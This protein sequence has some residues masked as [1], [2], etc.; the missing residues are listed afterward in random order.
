M[1]NRRTVQRL[2]MFLSFVAIISVVAI[3][4]PDVIFKDE[5]PATHNRVDV[6]KLQPGS[7]VEVKRD[8][9]HVFV[10]RDFAGAIHIF[11]IPFW[12]GAYWL[13]EFDWTHP[14]VPCA[15]FGPDNNDGTLVIDGRFRCREPDHGEFFRREH[16]WTYAG[17]NK[18]YRTVDLKTAKH[19]IDENVVV[20]PRA[21]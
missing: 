6:S 12:D 21:E 8:S 17:E 1:M 4:Y 15:I 2:I 11:T 16:S 7:F 9:S 5:V 20:L 18:G 19:E 13:P 3:Y 10:L 14:A